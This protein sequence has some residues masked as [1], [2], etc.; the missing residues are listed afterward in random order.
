MRNR[1]EAYQLQ[2]NRATTNV[3]VLLRMFLRR[4]LVVDKLNKMQMYTL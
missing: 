1:K 3:S 4:P 2:R